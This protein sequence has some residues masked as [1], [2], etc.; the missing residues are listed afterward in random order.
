VAHD[1]RTGRAEPAGQPPRC[2]GLARPDRPETPRNEASSLAAA[3]PLHGP[4][5]PTRAPAP[6]RIAPCGGGPRASPRAR[7]GPP[8]R[9][10]TRRVTRDGVR[11]PRRPTPAT[12][13]TVRASDLGSELHLPCEFAIEVSHVRPRRGPACGRPH[14]PVSAPE[15]VRGTIRGVL[16]SPSRSSQTATRSPRDGRDR[17]TASR[18]VRAAARDTIAFGASEQAVFAASVM[19]RGARDVT[20]GIARCAPRGGASACS[21]G[22]GAGSSMRPHDRRVTDRSVGS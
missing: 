2:A 9:P 14:R 1:P 10:G 11:R 13:P 15:V 12:R 22:A 4:W 8:R 19:T 21:R 7:R 5:W 3:G 6:P 18:L 16:A 17:W 20:R